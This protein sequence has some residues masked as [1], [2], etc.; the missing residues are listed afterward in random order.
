MNRFDHRQRRSA[1]TLLELLVSSVLTALLMIALLS[2]LRSALQT[3]RQAD[4]LNHRSASPLWL[5][6]QIERDIRNARGIQAGPNEVRLFGSLGRDK[7]GMPNYRPAYVGYR[8]G[9]NG[10]ARW[11]SGSVDP[12]RGASLVWFGATQLRVDLASSDDDE[13]LTRAPDPSQTGGLQPIPPSVQLIVVD[14]FAAPVVSLD[15]DHHR[16]SF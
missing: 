10:L 14:Q 4:N 3:S 6:E 15:I 8:I 9:R 11:E 13:S 12:G 1:F 7:N 5:A 2:V 16:E